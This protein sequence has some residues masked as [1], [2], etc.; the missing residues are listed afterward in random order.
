MPGSVPDRRVAS[1]EVLDYSSKSAWVPV[2]AMPS[3]R[4]DFYAF[5][6]GNVFYVTGGLE[7][8]STYW[9][10][11]SKSI[12]SYNPDSDTWKDVG[13]MTRE[14]LYHGGT[15][16]PLDA[17]KSFCPELFPTSGYH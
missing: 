5:T 1:T 11:W 3:A 7:D 9:R 14:R 12:V 13:N 8:R 15:P 10:H 16:V 6:V 17:M 4:Q 2:A